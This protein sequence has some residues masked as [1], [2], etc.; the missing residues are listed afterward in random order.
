MV[1][2]ERLWALRLLEGEDIAEHLNKFW[3]LANQVE[4]LSAIGKRIAHNELVTL[5]CL[6]L[7]DSYEPMIMALQSRADELTFDIF[8]GRLL[9]E[10]ARR[11][12]AQVRQPDQEQGASSGTAFTVRSPMRGRRNIDARYRLRR[13]GTRTPN[14]FGMGRVEVHL[15]QKG[16]AFTIRKMVIGNVTVLR[17]RQMSVRKYYP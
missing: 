6:S 8:A 16:N 2:I 10:S 1:L 5:L 9:Q 7:P 17:E 4:S 3:E 13:G 15:K 14:T 12:V 11:Q